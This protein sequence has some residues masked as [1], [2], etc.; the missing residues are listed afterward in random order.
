M[1]HS[2]CR[3]QEWHITVAGT[4][5][6]ERARTH[7]SDLMHSAAASDWKYQPSH[8]N[9]CWHCTSQTADT[10]H[11]HIIM[12]QIHWNL[13]MLWLMDGLLNRPRDRTEPTR[14]RLKMT[15]QYKQTQ[16]NN[17]KRCKTAENRHNTTTERCKTTPQRF[18]VTKKRQKGDLKWLHSVTMIS[19]TQKAVTNR[20]KW[21]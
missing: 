17:K 18:T 16:N 13:T 14:K 7:D 20:L 11:L 2:G 10:L 19:K 12:L 21:L 15:K 3:W 9:K 5:K 1:M 4:T 8:Q 6:T